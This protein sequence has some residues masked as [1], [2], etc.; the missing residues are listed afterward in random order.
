MGQFGGESVTFALTRQWQT[1]R[2]AL[3]RVIPV[4]V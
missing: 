4:T 1:G 2:R 3:V